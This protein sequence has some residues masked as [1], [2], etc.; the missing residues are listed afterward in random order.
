M[1]LQCERKR[2]AMTSLWPLLSYRPVRSSLQKAGDETM[3]QG[4]RSATQ[5][6]WKET[7]NPPL[8]VAVGRLVSGPSRGRNAWAVSLFDPHAVG[9]LG[10]L[11]QI[12]GQKD[13]P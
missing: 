2:L 13:R 7:P 8:T 9:V 11:I 12:L 5:S 3:G 6:N 4:E 10:L 1:K